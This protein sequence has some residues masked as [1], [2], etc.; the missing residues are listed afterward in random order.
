MIEKGDAFQI[1]EFLQENSYKSPGY[2]MKIYNP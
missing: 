1:D 2:N